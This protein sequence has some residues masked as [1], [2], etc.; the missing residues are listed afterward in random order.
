L[1]ILH[2]SASI[3]P[4]AIHLLVLSCINWIGIMDV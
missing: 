4:I 1:A 3:E 2:V